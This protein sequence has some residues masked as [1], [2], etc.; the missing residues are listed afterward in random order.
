MLINFSI[1]KQIRKTPGVRQ[2]KEFITE[3]SWVW[4][5]ISSQ[6]QSDKSN[7]HQNSSRM[8][9]SPILIAEP[10]CVYPRFRKLDLR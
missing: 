6:G 2:H 3:N 9:H 10:G 5:N 8:C 7:V 4:K 1:R